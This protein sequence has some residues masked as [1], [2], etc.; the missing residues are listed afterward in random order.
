MLFV[1]KTCFQLFNMSFM[2]KKN[3]NVNPP[4]TLPYGKKSTLP[5]TLPRGWGGLG[6]V[7]KNMTQDF[8]TQS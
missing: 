7:K 8:T 5:L 4:L 1:Y 2:I 3:K 6:R